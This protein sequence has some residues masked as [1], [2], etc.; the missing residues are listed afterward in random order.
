M[1]RFAFNTGIVAKFTPG[2]DIDILNPDAAAAVEALARE[3]FEE[4]GDVLVRIGSMPPSGPE[5]R[6]PSRE[7]VFK[8]GK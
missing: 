4:R 2:L 6:K 1:W 7:A 8:D 3:H 5:R